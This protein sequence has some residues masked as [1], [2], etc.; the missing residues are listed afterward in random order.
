MK[1]RDSRGVQYDVGARVAYN[2]SGNVIAGEVVHITASMVKIKPD[3]EWQGGYW[4]HISHVKNR[5][6]ILVIS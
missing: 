1:A 6:S 3:N 5:N 4:P 2:R